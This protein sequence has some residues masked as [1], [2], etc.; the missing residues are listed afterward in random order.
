MENYRVSVDLGSE[1]M[2]R[3]LMKINEL[4]YVHESSFQSSA[5]RAVTAFGHFSP[6]QPISQKEKSPINA[7][8]LTK[9]ANFRTPQTSFVYSNTFD[10]DRRYQSPPFHNFA[11]KPPDQFSAALASAPHKSGAWLRSCI[12]YNFTI[13]ARKYQRTRE[14]KVSKPPGPALQNSYTHSSP[15]LCPFSASSDYHSLFTTATELVHV[16]EPMRLASSDVLC[17]RRR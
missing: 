12:V 13:L 10:F 16:L 1:L 9:Q 4:Y 3:Q 6:S 5:C 14:V 17:N 11:P 2:K 7:I 8:Y 15:F